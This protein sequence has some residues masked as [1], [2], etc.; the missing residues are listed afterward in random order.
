MNKLSFINCNL[1]R[2]HLAGTKQKDV[3]FK[4]S[5]TAEAIHE[6]DEQ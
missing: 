6:T 3:L 4:S 1:K 5:N 2:V